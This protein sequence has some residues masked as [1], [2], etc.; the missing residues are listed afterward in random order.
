MACRGKRRTFPTPK[1]PSW[2]GL[3]C[4]ASAVVIAYLT[5]MRTGEVLNLERGCVDQD[6][7]TGLWFITGKHWKTARDDNGHK[8]PEGERRPDP[9]DNRPTGWGRGGSTRA[10]T[11]S[12][13]TD[14]A[15]LHPHRTTGTRSVTRPAQGRTAKD[16]PRDI[17]ALT[18]WVNAYCDAHGLSDRI[19]PDPARPDR[20]IPIPPNAGLA[21]RPPPAR[22][23]RRCNPVRSPTCPNDAR[24]R[25]IIRLRFSRRARLRRL[26]VPAGHPSRKPSATCRRRTHQRACRHNYRHRTEAAHQKFGGRVL[27]NNNQARDL[28][29]N[30][31]LQIY[32]GRAMTC[33]FDPS[34]A[35]CQLRTAEDDV[36]RTPDQDDCQPNCQN[37]AFT[38]RNISELR[39]RA[40][41]LREITADHLTPSPRH[42]RERA[43]LERIYTIIHTHDHGR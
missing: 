9:V 38:D 8:I 25:R 13:T 2:P 31:L 26:A 4:T 40:A 5:G 37:I 24:L 43:E 15:Q 1:H 20:T 39:Q 32:P 7:V 10:A 12:A 18:E 33:V 17:A 22:A 34:K 23:R 16:L 6:A 36:R 27:T 19:L 42:Q 41:S 3:L 21:H 28:I 29:T 14:P 30:P 11:P 35:L